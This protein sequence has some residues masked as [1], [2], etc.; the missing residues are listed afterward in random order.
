MTQAATNAIAPKFSD[1]VRSF[2]NENA[3]TIISMFV[4]HDEAYQKVLKT[5]VSAQAP[6]IQ[7]NVVKEGA[8]IVL[9]SEDVGDEDH[10][11]L[12]E[13]VSHGYRLNAT[14]KRLSE[15]LEKIS[16]SLK[17]VASAKIALYNDNQ[18][19]KDNKVK[20]L[21]IRGCSQ[22][23]TATISVKEAYS[24]K[25]DKIASLKKQIGKKLFDAAFSE[26]E[27][28]TV[29]AEFVEE[30]LAAV[31]KIFTKVEKVLSKD[32]KYG[33]KS[34][35]AYDEILASPDVTETVKAALR[36]AVKQHDAAI[37]YGD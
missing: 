8:V 7:D 10:K 16:V 14:I 5:A 29:K 35:E 23:H 17:Q 30:V 15:E 22:E 28:Y 34:K 33:L 2:D 18:A 19:D 32:V 21:R 20:S 36:E 13:A 6:A 27:T 25:H 12:S 1:V 9:N 3:K 4:G 26:T 11:V 24:I 31:K 37:K